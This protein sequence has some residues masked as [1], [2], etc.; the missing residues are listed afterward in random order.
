MVPS[1]RA[2]PLGWTEL[3]LPSA[4]ALDTPCVAV[5]HYLLL[6]AAFLKESLHKR[7]GASVRSRRPLAYFVQLEERLRHLLVDLYLRK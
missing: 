2:L 6:L 5:P 1:H 7:E 3:P 4:H